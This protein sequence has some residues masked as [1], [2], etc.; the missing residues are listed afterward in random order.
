MQFIK[1]PDADLDFK[2]D[3]ADWLAAVDDTI[4]SSEWILPVGL[5]LG[6]G[7][8]S[9]DATTATIWIKG[10]TTGQRYSV[11]NRITTAGGRI[12]D[13]TFVIVIRER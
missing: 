1:D 13:R 11:T 6:E 10:G 8:Q 7:G 4:E 2:R 3:W 9:Y 5:E 12:D